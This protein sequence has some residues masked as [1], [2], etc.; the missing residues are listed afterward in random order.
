MHLTVFTLQTLNL[1]MKSAVF[2]C[3]DIW[4]MGTLSAD[5]EGDDSRRFKDKSALYS[6][7]ISYTALRWNELSVS[8]A[9][10]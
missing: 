6:H 4:N 10:K 2:R 1:Q 8:N 5:W 7:P 9:S 3:L